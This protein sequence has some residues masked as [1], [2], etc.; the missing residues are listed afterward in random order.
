MRR[1]EE[2]RV[3]VEA[4]D[5][6]NGIALENIDRLF[7]PFDRLG[8]EGGDVEGTGLGLALSKRLIEAMGGEIGVKSLI[9]SGSAFWVKIPRSSNPM[10]RAHE[11]GALPESVTLVKACT[12]LYIEDNLSN[13]TLIEYLLSRRPQIKLLAAMQG[14]LGI[15]MAREH[16]PDLILLDLHLPDIMGNEVLACLKGDAATR[17]IPVAMLTADATPGQE[18]RLRAAGA[19]HYLTK[20]IDVPQLLLL[21]EETLGGRADDQSKT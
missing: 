1:Q 2:R 3:P 15:E 14:R 5:T 11:A 21:I 19:D 17:N 6:G 20:P 16:H 13:L 12:I 9:G 10:A 7:F 4:R 8:V 18:A